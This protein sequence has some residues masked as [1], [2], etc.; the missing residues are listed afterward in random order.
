M[1]KIQVRVSLAQLVEHLTLNQRAAGSKPARDTTK[2]SFELYFVSDKI[3]KF[4]FYSCNR[5]LGQYFGKYK[6]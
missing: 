2:F 1:N 6:I 5:F 4:Q 3:Q